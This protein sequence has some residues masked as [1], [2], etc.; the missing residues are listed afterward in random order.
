MVR[1]QRAGGSGEPTG[2]PTPTPTPVPP[3]PPTLKPP[4]P[5]PTLELGCTCDSVTHVYQ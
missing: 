3:L 4:I 5:I 1:S 2:I